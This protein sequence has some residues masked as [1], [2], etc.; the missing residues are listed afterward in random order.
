MS[1]QK[2]MC[3]TTPTPMVGEMMPRQEAVPKEMAKTATTDQ[4]KNKMVPSK[5]ESIAT[6]STNKEVMSG[7]K[8]GHTTIFPKK[9]LQPIKR[10]ESRK[11]KEARKAEIDS[12]DDDDLLRA[13]E[14]LEK[15]VTHSDEE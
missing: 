7:T 5:E 10:K 9:K 8:K 6:T 2:A 12:S 3:P 15:V 11:I 1:E 14:A 13:A 4:F